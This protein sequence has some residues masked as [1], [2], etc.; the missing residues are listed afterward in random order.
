LDPGAH[1]LPERRQG[2]AIG[3]NL[4]KNTYAAQ[5][6]KYPIERPWMRGRGLRELGAAPRAAG[7]NIGDAQL[8]SQPER[9]RDDGAITQEK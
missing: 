5:Y 8:G 1:G 7:E 2:K 3:L 9:R 4:G 6:P